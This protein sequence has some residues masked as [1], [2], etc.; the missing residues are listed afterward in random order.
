MG[1]AKADSPSRL[2]ISH[3]AAGLRSQGNGEDKQSPDQHLR[4]QGI[5]NGRV[6]DIVCGAVRVQEMRCNRL[7][8]ASVRRARRMPFLLGAGQ[9]M[10]AT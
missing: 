10:N 5:V 8:W 1:G 7:V 6:F 9:F 4:Q 2:R 3:G